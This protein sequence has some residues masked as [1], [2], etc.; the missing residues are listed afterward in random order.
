MLP[1]VFRPPDD[2]DR[3]SAWLAW[4]DAN[5]L[6][7]AAARA[8]AAAPL[9]ES[10]RAHL[11][12]A[13]ARARA[14]WLLRK[15][16]LQRFLALIA[17]EPA[18]P[19]ILLKG[20]ALALTL[21]DD[22]AVRPMN[23]IDLLVAPEHLMAVAER[24]RQGGYEESSLGAGGDAGYLHH[25]IFTDPVTS[26]RIELH[27]TLP[28]LP[29]ATLSLFLARTPASDLAGLPFFTLAPEAQLLHLASHAVL[30]H[31]GEQGAVWIWF[32]D[33]DRLLRRWGEEMDW[34]KTLAWAQQLN[35][36]AALHEALRI[37]ARD[38]S[39]PMPATISTWLQLP[40][41]KLRGYN[42]MR[43]MTSPARSSSL[44]IF[45]VL[46]GLTW[47]QRL[48]QIWHMSFPS[49]DYMKRRYPNIPWPAAY[50]YRWFDAARKLLPALLRE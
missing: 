2:A 9:P 8:L 38:F 23:D 32:Y 13:Y 40:Q 10:A 42:T 46:R 21:Y 1:P 41:S 28:L 26:V 45:H 48:R 27:R 17:R 47:R 36:E 35:W 31:G 29:N 3:L 25:F 33:I 5:R 44:T 14:Q 43:Q 24:L 19:V 22:P 4:L 39:A 6:A 20:A 49:R 12:A 37:T 18:L 15:T 50:P 30:E 16:A 7:P 11:D 34:E